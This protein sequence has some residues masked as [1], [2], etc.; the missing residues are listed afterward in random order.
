MHHMYQFCRVHATAIGKSTGCKG[1]YAL[2][3][4]PQHNPL[5]QAVPDAMHTIK[6]VIVHVFNLITGREDGDKVHAS[7]RSIQRFDV[8]PAGTRCSSTL[9]YRLSPDDVKLAN[10]RVAMVNMPNP[11]FTPLNIFST[12]ARLK[13]HDWKEVSA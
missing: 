8:P 7:E 5:K 2:M 4:L 12:T 6:D 1:M 10:S 11:D 3:H 13:S 9:C